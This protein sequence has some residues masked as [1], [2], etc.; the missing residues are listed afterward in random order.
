MKIPIVPIGNSKGI[1]LNKI[2][3]EKYAIQDTVELILQ[4]DC[5]VLKPTTVSRKGW[6]KAFQKMQIHGDDQ[7]LIPD[8]MDDENFE[9]W[10]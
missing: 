6:D 10:K 9:E 5:I 7:L 4:E 8:V 2:L 3:I 1:R